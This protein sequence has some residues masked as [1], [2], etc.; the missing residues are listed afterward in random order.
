MRS[1]TL[2]FF[3][4]VASLFSAC[5]QQ[6]DCSASTCSGCCDADGACQA[7]NL[8]NACG[9]SGNQCVACPGG[10]CNLG[11][12]S[13]TGTGG[14]NGSTGGGT[15]M[16]GG[17]A[18]GGGTGTLVTFT[19]F[20]TAAVNAQYD[21]YVRCGSYTRA[22][23][24]A[25]VALALVNCAAEPALFTSGRARFNPAGA[26]SCIDDY[27]SI[28][29]TQGPASSGCPGAATGLVA[30]GGTCY[31]FSECVAGHWCDTNSACPGTC[32]PRVAIGQPS[33]TM[34]G[35]DCAA[36]AYRYGANCVA[37]IAVGMECGPQGG[38]SEA[39]YCVNG[40]A[41]STS[42]ERCVAG[43]VDVGGTC[44]PNTSP[45]CREG[46][47]CV[48]NA[49]VAYGD[50]NSPCDSVRRCKQGLQCGAANVCVAFGVAGSACGTGNPQCGSG[51]FC[52]ISSGTTGVCTTLRGTNGTCTN[53]GQCQS[54][55]WCNAPQGGSGACVAKL[56]TGAA[57]EKR[58]EYSACERDL[59]C[60]TIGTAAM[61]G[62]C[63]VRKG[64][65]ANCT[66]TEECK[67]DAYCGGGMCTRFSCS[68]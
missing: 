42:T 62:V 20:C 28:A 39:R 66:L 50:V 11:F 55:L 12:C 47:G 64:S 68:P 63:A 61:S 36:D 65:G 23:A 21:Y 45:E 37:R 58:N 52:N 33:A 51:L 53:N 40:A 15:A 27:R 3:I 57:C 49:C 2:C 41:C 25:Y 10:A 29:C 5:P 4:S 67:L 43:F 54:A 35:E 34:Y 59:Y 56:S 18:T 14:G 38:M 6:K 48:S 17:S 7:G 26:Q 30:N 1:L 44:A 46:T 16:G 32:K 24:D 19:D 9:A 31:Q 22:A 13:N 8:A 60:T